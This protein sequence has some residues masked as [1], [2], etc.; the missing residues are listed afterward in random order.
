MEKELLNYVNNVVNEIEKNYDKEVLKRGT[1]GLAYKR[2]MRL[3]KYIEEGNDPFIFPNDFLIIGGA[4]AYSDCSYSNV[5]FF[6]EIYENMCATEKILKAKTKVDKISCDVEK[7][8]EY[9]KK[10]EDRARREQ[11]GYLGLNRVV[12]NIPN[13]L[14]SKNGFFIDIYMNIK[15]KSLFGEK[16]KVRSNIKEKWPMFFLGTYKYPSTMEDVLSDIKKIEIKY[17][18]SGTGKCDK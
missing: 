14:E 10:C 5:E 16:T 15:R 12:D 8:K 11:Y 6:S 3:K 17:G 1:I 2:Y 9:D 13:E 18:A 7:L 4:H